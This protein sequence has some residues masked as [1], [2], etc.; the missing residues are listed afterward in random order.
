MNITM[1]GLLLDRIERLA[2]QVGALRAQRDTP[3]LLPPIGPFTATAGGPPATPAIG[4]VAR[5]VLRKLVQISR[6][7]PRYRGALCYPSASG[8]DLLWD[9][10][11]ALR[12]E[13]EGQA[14]KGAGQ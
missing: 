10:I 5:E 13:M 12:A 8:K 9:D 14:E 2:E 1:D 7:C 4:P 3:V 11:H 6:D